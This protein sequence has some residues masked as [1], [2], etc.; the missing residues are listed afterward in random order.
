[1]AILNKNKENQNYFGSTLSMSQ[2]GQCCERL[3]LC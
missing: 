2:K 3:T 1:M